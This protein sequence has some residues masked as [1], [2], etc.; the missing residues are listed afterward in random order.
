MF[1]VFWGKGEDLYIRQNACI[2]DYSGAREFWGGL[3][4]TF[5]IVHTDTLQREC[6]LY[7]T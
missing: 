3:T 6:M 1:S 7:S 2:Y 5:P 4:P